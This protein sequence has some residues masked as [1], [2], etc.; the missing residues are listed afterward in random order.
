MCSAPVTFGGGIAIEKFSSGVPLGLGVEDPGPLPAREH[1]RLDLGG[2]VARALLE[3]L[4]RSSAI[5]PQVSQ[6]AEY[7]WP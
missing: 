3:R 6:R 5:E 4:Q 2:L 7:L 1:A